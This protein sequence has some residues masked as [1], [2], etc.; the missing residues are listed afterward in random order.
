MLCRLFYPFETYA[1]DIGMTADETKRDII[2]ANE[3]MSLILNHELTIPA[4]YAARAKSN[5][6]L[7][8]GLS[9]P[10]PLS[11]AVMATAIMLHGR[12]FKRD[13]EQA[14]YDRCAAGNSDTGGSDPHPLP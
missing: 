8:A 14:Y 7:P 6:S 4:V 1:L 9:I 13:S 10:G 11:P 5:G 12:I 2:D 3:E